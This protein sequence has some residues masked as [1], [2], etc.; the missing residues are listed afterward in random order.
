MTDVE[1]LEVGLGV[2]VVLGVEVLDVGVGAG[3]VPDGGPVDATDLA[4]PDVDATEVAAASD[5]PVSG[6]AATTPTT[7]RSARIA[8]S[9]AE[10]ILCL[11]TKVLVETLR[12]LTASRDSIARGRLHAVRQCEGRGSL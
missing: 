8:A 1:V 9:T 4:A 11:L 10:R 5:P 3:V 12:F 7:T 6:A 2:G